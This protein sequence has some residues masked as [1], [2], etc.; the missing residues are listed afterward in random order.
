VGFASSDTENNKTNNNNDNRFITEVKYKGW[1]IDTLTQYYLQHFCLYKQEN[2]SNECVR[3]WNSFQE[4]RHY[5]ECL[6]QNVFYICQSEGLRPI[7]VPSCRINV[8][9]L[10]KL[11]WNASTLE[12]E[13]V[14]CIVHFLICTEMDDFSSFIDNFS[15]ISD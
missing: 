12:Q 13:Y 2:Y 10:V 11:Q 6:A 15:C 14:K 5:E 4:S 7:T 8:E 1:E 3:S 9:L